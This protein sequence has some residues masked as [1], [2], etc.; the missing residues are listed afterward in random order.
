MR[1][2][3]VMAFPVRIQGVFA[4]LA[5]ASIA[6]CGGG[7]SAG[8]TGG[9]TARR[10]RG[11]V[12]PAAAAARRSSRPRERAAE[13]EAAARPADRSGP[14]DPP[15]LAEARAR[16]AAAVSPVR[17]ARLVP[18]ARG[19][20]ARRAQAVAGAGAGGST[21]SG[22]ACGRKRA[23]RSAGTGT[24]GDR[25]RRASGGAA[26]GGGARAAPRAAPAR[27]RTGGAG[28]SGGVSGLPARATVID[29]LRR[30]NT[31]FVNK[32][33]D[34]GTQIDSSHAEPHLDAR[35]VL[36]RADGAERRRSAGELRRLRGPLGHQPQLGPRRR[37]HHAQRGQPVRGPDV[38]RP[39]QHG[40]AG[41][42][43]ARH[44]GRHRHGRVG[45]RRE[46]LDLGRCHPDGD[47]GL[48]EAGQA[49]HVDRLHRQGVRD[50]REHEERPG[51]QR[52]LQQDGSPVV[53]RSGL[54]SALHRAER[55]ELLLV[56][57]QR[58][59]V[60]GADPHARHHPGQ[61]SASRRVPRRLP[62]DGG[63]AARRPAQR[64]VLERQPV[65]PDALRRPRADRHVA[66]H[67]RDGVGRPDGRAVVGDIRAR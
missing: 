25:R 54:R 19:R 47:A 64:R 56:A 24:A 8:G 39:L 34:P 5:L 28:G 21:G 62:G 32:W 23:R 18:A 57:R 46:R 6:A 12:R 67:L 52:P 44:Q 27:Q 13:R 61:R 15:V 20:A 55:Q 60:R 36:R 10:R 31:Y 41:D 50:V 45:Q 58:L 26:G 9:R 3:S 1:T 17:A 16:R 29:L 49:R 35:R 48:R 65:R 7:N 51:R 42:A 53:A 59:G 14:R 63:G 33:P 2:F 38:H 22:G 30:A 37:H 43:H 11:V 40:R 4:A 66:V